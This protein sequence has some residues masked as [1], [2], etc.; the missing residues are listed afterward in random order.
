MRADVIKIPTVK[1]LL[2]ITG[3]NLV[4]ITGGTLFSTITVKSIQSNYEKSLASVRQSER[5][6]QTAI[7]LLENVS[8]EADVINARISASIEALTA[9]VKRAR[10]KQI[11]K[12]EGEADYVVDAAVEARARIRGAESDVDQL[13]SM[14]KDKISLDFQNFSEDLLAQHTRINSLGEEIS[15]ESQNT[16]GQIRVSQSKVIEL[17]DR[18][19][20]ELHNL[21]QRDLEFSKQLRADML[22]SAATLSDIE[23]QTSEVIEKGIAQFRL[24][25]NQSEQELAAA[26]TELDDIRLALRIGQEMMNEIPATGSPP[27]DNSRI[28]KRPETD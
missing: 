1:F 25:M 12:I 15:Q 19:K 17:S 27:G 24:K 20:R 14:S 11:L 5:E 16:M 4:L 22:Q 21:N 8:R 28:K 18:S 10:D 9:D 6:Y 13:V 3:L 26:L 7:N 2:G 23:N